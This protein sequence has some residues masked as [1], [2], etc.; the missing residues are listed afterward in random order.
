M[1]AS[2]FNFEFLKV[3]DKLQFVTTEVLSKG[4][5]DHIF[6][7]GD[8][9]TDYAE[10]RAIVQCPHCFKSWFN[11]S[12]SDFE[13]NYLADLVKEGKVAE[14]DVSIYHLAEITK[15]GDFTFG[16]LRVCRMQALF[17]EAFC[18]VECHG[19]SAD[20]VL[21]SGAGSLVGAR[22]TNKPLLIIR[23]ICESAA[24]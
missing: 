3:T 10:V 18:S 23:V 21:W 4:T 17:N 2:I 9:D 19:V 24:K 20:E 15:T 8:F 14:D 7:D 16:T 22:L 1:S 13:K 11:I 6:F 5:W 12:Y